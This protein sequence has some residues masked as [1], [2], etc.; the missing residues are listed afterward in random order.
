MLVQKYR[1]KIEGKFISHKSRIVGDLIVNPEDDM[2][3]T[4]GFIAD[5]DVPSQKATIVFFE[6]E[7]ISSDFFIDYKL[8]FISEELLHDD[9]QEDIKRA[10]LP[11]TP[12]NIFLNA[13][14]SISNEAEDLS[15]YWD[16]I[17][18]DDDRYE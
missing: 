13:L 8:E 2:D 15:D 16:D 7:D 9:L 4:K 18:E 3:E 5:F 17:E 6:P 11:G 14:D 12:L 10:N 1:A